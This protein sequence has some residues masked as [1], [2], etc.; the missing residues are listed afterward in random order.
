M[1]ES[2][3]MTLLDASACNLSQLIQ[4]IIVDGLGNMGRNRD[5]LNRMLLHLVIRQGLQS[6]ILISNRKQGNRNPGDDHPDPGHWQPIW[7]ICISCCGL[8][9]FQDGH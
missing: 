8:R 2:Q 5:M 6:S 7:L 3:P 9:I 1:S 4:L